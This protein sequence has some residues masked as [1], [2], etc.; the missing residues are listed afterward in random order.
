MRG[1][2]PR[3]TA[4]KQ[5]FHHEEEARATKEHRMALR[6][7]VLAPREAPKFLP[8]SWSFVV[9]SVVFVLKTLLAV[10]QHAPADVPSGNRQT[11]TSRGN[12]NGVRR[13]A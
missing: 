13:R 12:L 2:P 3:S 6:G 8:S 10:L 7:F 4:G 1:P 11:D 9:L 5:D